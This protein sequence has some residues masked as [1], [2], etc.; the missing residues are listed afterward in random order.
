M[1]ILSIVEIISKLSGRF[2]NDSYFTLNQRLEQLLRLSE[3]EF[4][5]ELHNPFLVEKKTPFR[6]VIYKLIRLIFPFDEQITEYLA[7]GIAA[8]SRCP[9]DLPDSPGLYPEQIQAAIVLTQRAVLQMDTGEGKTYALLPA[10]YALARKH[11]R[12]YV[13]CANEYLAFRDATRTK[14]YWDY[15]GLS[16]SYCSRNTYHADQKWGENIIYTTLNGIA[17][18]VMGDDLNGCPPT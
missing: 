4:K 1:N 14:N 7:K 16:V 12:I 6:A 2:V 9:A 5:Q 18:K 10:A 17:F 15:V 13:I 3:S 11:G 8:F